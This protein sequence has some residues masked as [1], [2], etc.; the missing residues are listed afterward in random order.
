L[1]KL[2]AFI[3]DEHVY[4]LA[5]FEQPLSFSTDEAGFLKEWTNFF[6]KSDYAEYIVQMF[7]Y[8]V[9]IKFIVHLKY[10]DWVVPP[11]SKL[12]RLGHVT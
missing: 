4:Y 6:P 9:V 7:V 11:C 8:F 10:E 12:N 2:V 1:L 3:P 5:E